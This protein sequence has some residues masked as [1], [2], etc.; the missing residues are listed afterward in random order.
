[1]ECTDVTVDTEAWLDS[2]RGATRA[3][4]LVAK[5]ASDSAPLLGSL[6]LEE[7]PA[8]DKQP[9]PRPLL[10]ALIVPPK[11]RRR[12]IATRL[13]SAA[14][15]QASAWGH[16][17][18]ELYVQATDAAAVGLYDALGF[19]DAETGERVVVSS[20]DAGGGVFAWARA[21]ASGGGR[22]VCLRKRL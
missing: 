19:R 13:V 17:E 7:L 2:F 10:S 3:V 22:I 15:A 1:M 6:G 8:T 14:E 12:G 16:D 4:K 21:L 18:L 5:E 20:D 9:R 11:H